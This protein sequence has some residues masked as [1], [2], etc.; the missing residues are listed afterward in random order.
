M[1]DD[2]KPPQR[3]RRKTKKIEPLEKP[4]GPSIFEQVSVEEPDFDV[5]KETDTGSIILP[6]PV[7]IAVSHEQPK[8][9][10]SWSKLPW[11]P[12]RKQSIIYGVVV[13][14]LVF[15]VGA[16]W[17]MT[18]RRTIVAE[19][20]KTIVKKKVVKPA[21]PPLY[22]TLTGLPI[23]DPAINALPVTAV[24]IEN[25]VEARP[26]SGLSE[27]G[28]VFEAVAEG[29]VTRF[30]ALFQD[31]APDNVGPVRS[32]RPYYVSW[33]TGFDAAYAHVG[34]SPDGLDAIKAWGT[35]DMNQ[36]YNG[37]SYH[38]VSSRAA[39]H[40]V[41]TSIATLHE[42]EASKGFTS[43]F[44][45]FTRKS[46][47][48]YKTPVAGTNGQI[49]KDADTRTAAN[50]I[51]M[52]LSGYTYDPH[53]AYNSGN[54]SYDRTMAGAPH[55][56]AN[57]NR[58]ISPKVVIAMVVP[59][60]RGELDSSNAYYSN[61]NVVG[62]G[63]AYIFQDGTVSTGQ[64]HKAGNSTGLSFTDVTGASFP[65]NRGQTWITAIS[66]TSNVSYK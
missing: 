61:Y 45:G 23:T 5:H 66:T 60:S 55:T 48:P 8:K 2:V 32:A 30:M 19:K 9:H 25:S 4:N 46:D 49:P 59:L 27:A 54:N 13:L 18:H 24:M 52:S 53:F 65:L 43:T 51:N 6:P 39:P 26:Q 64:W 34:G 12:T 7:P 50:A 22:S 58:Q 56:D 62:D 41:Y 42:L 16:G 17:T 47:Q 15:G 40:N 38:R 35:K 37:N 10:R 20:P 28:V 63:Q 33:A 21:P 3:Q 57:G 44:T 29:G 14:L 36:F 1:F 11:P 31:S